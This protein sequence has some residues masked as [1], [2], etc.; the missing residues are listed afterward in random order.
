MC[1]IV[2]VNNLMCIYSSTEF[3]VWDDPHAGALVEIW[4]CTRSVTRYSMKQQVQRRLKK[5][6]IQSITVQS[7]VLFLPMY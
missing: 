5:N 3:K 2:H 6:K 7:F 1:T 4:S